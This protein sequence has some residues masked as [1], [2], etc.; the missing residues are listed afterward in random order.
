V[1]A[2]LEYEFSEI[3]FLAVAVCFEDE[4][5]VIKVLGHGSLFGG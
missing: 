3:N 1:A 5:S 2:S 4:L